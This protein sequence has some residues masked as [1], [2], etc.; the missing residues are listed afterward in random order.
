MLEGIEW[1]AEGDRRSIGT[2]RFAYLGTEVMPDGGF[3]TALE[4]Q[5]ARWFTDRE[6]LVAAQSGYGDLI[7]SLL[8]EVESSRAAREALEAATG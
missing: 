3:D 1:S 4:K 6:A 8:A 7:S 2:E 5:Y